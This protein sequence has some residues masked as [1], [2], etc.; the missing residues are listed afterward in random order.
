MKPTEQ[1]QL[2]PT[3]RLERSD[4]YQRVGLGT[5]DADINQTYNWRVA[6]GEIGEGSLTLSASTGIEL[7]NDWSIRTHLAKP[8]FSA[9]LNNAFVHT[10][11][12]SK[13]WTQAASADIAAY[14]PASKTVA[15]YVIRS[16]YKL[17][18]SDG[19]QLA[20]TVTYVNADHV[21]FRESLAADAEPGDRPGALMP[22]GQ[23]VSQEVPTLAPQVDTS[24]EIT[25]DD[26]VDNTLAP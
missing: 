8:H 2:S 7:A 24:L 12:S 19:T 16:E 26:F 22:A 14:I 20:D 17:L 25:L 15:A 23:P 10:G 9:R 18:R 13:G 21:Y 5:N 1:L 6:K 3:Y 11:Q 4:Q